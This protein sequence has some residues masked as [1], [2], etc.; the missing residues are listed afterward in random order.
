MIH[1]NNLFSEIEKGLEGGNVGL[2]TGLPKLDEIIAGVQR[3]TIYNVT[4][5]ISGGK[6]SIASYA[7]VYQPLIQNLNNPSFKLIFFSLEISAETLLA[8]LLSLY[9]YET[10]NREISY[11]KLL[12]RTKNNKLST[13]EYVI[14]QACK[15]WLY[16]VE[17]IIYIYD[18]AL[19][20]DSFYAVVKGFAEVH[21]KFEDVD[22]HETIYTPYDSDLFVLAII[23]HVSL[24][25]TKG[26][27]QTKQ[28][29]D[30]VCSEAI[31]FRNK[32]SFSFV[33]LQQINR[34]SGS[35]DRRKAELQE[36]ELQDLKD[37]AGPSEA[38]DVVLA[39]FFPHRDKMSVYRKYKIAKGFRDAFRSIITLKNRYGECD[40]IVP[41]NFFGSI[42]LF[43]ELQEPEFY[44]TIIDYNP[45]VYLFPPAPTTLD[46]EINKIDNYFL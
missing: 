27:Q 38:A 31:Y 21:G 37:T 34:T 25:K 2:S 20:S 45:Y 19:T 41:V 22:D 39:L 18:R 15:D 9:I 7:F 4:A 33:L 44:D 32:C 16:K 5:P 12:S 35:M 29:I 43:R 40:Q 10:Y 23:D 3:K 36:I 28:A 17:K 14:V 6:T 24:I 8:K 42:G 11:K 26:S 30:T 1:T 13:E 46:E